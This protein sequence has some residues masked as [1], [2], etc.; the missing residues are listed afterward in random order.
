MPDGRLID[1]I[2]ALS[3]LPPNPTVADWQQAQNP[4]TYATPMDRRPAKIGDPGLSGRL[5]DLLRMAAAKVQDQPLVRLGNALTGGGFGDFATATPAPLFSMGE[6]PDKPSD[7]L[8]SEVI[9]RIA[10]PIKAYHGSPHDFDQ[11]SMD[12][13]GTGEGAQAY[14]HGLYFAEHPE[15]SRGYRDQVPATD[16]IGLGRG[17]VPL[18]TQIRVGRKS[19]TDVYSEIER[20]AGRLPHKDAEPLYERL[21]AL[22][23]LMQHGDMLGVQEAAQAGQVTP[24]ALAWMQ[25]EIAPKFNRRGKLYEVAIHADPES[26]LDWDKP[27]SQQSEKVRQALAAIGEPKAPFTPTRLSDGK[28]RI[29]G[30]DGRSWGIYNTPAEAE[31]AITNMMVGYSRVPRTQTGAALFERGAFSGIGAREGE[32]EL[33]ERLKKAGVSGVKYLDAA[34]RSAAD[35]SRNYVVFDDSLIEILRKYGLLPFAAGLASQQDQK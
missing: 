26:F 24:R 3:V 4:Q 35:G 6:M 22:E 21:S 30:M 16:R 20:Q 23:S 10:N 12:K 15:V 7:Q 8:R 13:I 5:V 19:V 31:E 28:V 34:S 32:R 11:F 2:R 18:D 33:S 17:E 1:V 9:K 14:G 25:K 27:L 29:D